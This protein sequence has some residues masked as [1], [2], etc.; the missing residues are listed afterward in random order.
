MRLGGFYGLTAFSLLLLDDEREVADKI[1]AMNA[2]MNATILKDLSKEFLYLGYTVDNFPF[3]YDCAG[4]NDARLL[5]KKCSIKDHHVECTSDEDYNSLL[6]ALAVHIALLVLRSQ[7][8]FD[9]GELKDTDVLDV[10]GVMMEI[11]EKILQDIDQTTLIAF[12]RKFREKYSYSDACDVSDIIIKAFSIEVTVNSHVNVSG[13]SYELSDDNKKVILWLKKHRS[14]IDALRNSINLVMSSD[15]VIFGVPFP[16]LI[17]RK[18]TCLYYAV[19]KKFDY[20]K[21]ANRE[22]LLSVI[23]DVKEEITKFTELVEKE[24]VFGESIQ[25]DYLTKDSYMDKVL[26]FESDKR[27]FFMSEVKDIY[28]PEDFSSESFTLLSDIYDLANAIDIDL[29]NRVLGTDF[30]KSS[31]YKEIRALNAL[32]FAGLN[33]NTMDL[34][35]KSIKDVMLSVSSVYEKSEEYHGELDTV[36]GDIRALLST[37]KPIGGELSV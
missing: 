29:I 27:A 32:G 16:A 21:S 26:A 2:D 37:L 20:A 23:A 25:S 12:D 5:L 10:P 24:V 6:Y 33:V 19:G 35:E 9:L 30:H 13:K 17:S 15:D 7:K 22:V 4:K 11:A 8:P 31:F 14:R 1:A 18:P 34:F 3:M 28:A 36:L